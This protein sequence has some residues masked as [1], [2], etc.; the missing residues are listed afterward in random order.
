MGSITFDKKRNKFVARAMID[1]K[2]TYLGQFDT[3][4]DAEFVILRSTPS[5]LSTY[6]APDIR[7]DVSFDWLF[8]IIWL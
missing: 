2:R 4:N 5:A 3:R 1:G 6:K 8:N 7:D